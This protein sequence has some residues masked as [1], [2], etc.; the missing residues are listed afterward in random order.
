VSFSEL[1]PRPPLPPNTSSAAKKG[2]IHMPL[3]GRLS[4]R[5]YSRSG[6]SRCISAPAD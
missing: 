1:L 2:V 4:D 6:D 5:Q 3:P